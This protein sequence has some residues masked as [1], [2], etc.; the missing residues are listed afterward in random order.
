MGNSKLPVSGF[1]WMEASEIERLDIFNFDSDG[2]IGMI[3]ECDLIYPEHL[4]DLHRDYPLAPENIEIS[5]DM[6]SPTAR[7]FLLENNMKFNTQ[8]RL[9]PNLMDK[10]SYVVHIKNLQFYLKQGLQLGRIT[11]VIEFN[12]TSWLKEYVDFNIEKRRLATTDF[13]VMLYKLLCN[14]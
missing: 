7:R 8:T 5:F 6:L 12:Q 13:H 3:L 14:G 9:A 4:H 11:R 10:Q 1:R 2:D